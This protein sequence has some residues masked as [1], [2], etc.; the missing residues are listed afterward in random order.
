MTQ[1]QQEQNAQ[2]QSRALKI[3]LERYRVDVEIDAQYTLLENVMSTYF[4]LKDGFHVFLKELSHP[5]R[6]WEFIIH[7][8]RGY[9]L[10]YFH[11]FKDHPQGAE[12]VGLYIDIFFRAIAETSRAK[13]K[14]DAVDNLLLYLMKVIKESGPRLETFRPALDEAFRRMAAYESPT[15][16]LI[17]T[18]YYPIKRLAKTLQGRTN[19]PATDLT[20][21]NRLLIK[22]FQ[23]TFDYWLGQS[24]PWQWF[25][26]EVSGSLENDIIKAIFDDISHTKLNKWQSELNAIVAHE[27]HSSAALLE[28]LLDLPGYDEIK[29]GYRKIPRALFSAGEYNGQANLWKIVFLFHIMNLSGLSLIHEEALREINRT[30]TW[31]IQN[32]NAPKIRLLL[33]KTFEILKEQTLMFPATALNCVLN[34]GKSV[35]Q[36]DDADLI[37]DFIEAVID[38]GFQ[39]PQISGVGNDWQI[40]V[41]SA[42]IQNIRTW[43]ELIKL[44]PKWSKRL[45]SSLIINLS[46]G[47]V[48]IKDT[49]LFFRDVSELLDSGTS[50][51]FNLV[52][53]LTRL[54]PIFFNEIGAEGKLRDTSTAV[55]ELTGR[56]DKLV[57]FLRK[58]SHVESSNRV[59]GFMEATLRFWKNRKKEELLPYVPPDVYETITNGGRY[60]DGVHQVMNRLTAKGFDL[61][62]GLLAADRSQLNAALTG[63]TDVPPM[64]IERV[65]L[66]IEFYKLLNLKYNLNF[67]EIDSLLEEAESDGL[68]GVEMLRKALHETDPFQKLPR[69]LTYLERLQS[70]ILAPESYEAREDIYKKRHFAV[71]IPSMYGS[72]REK[73]FDALG[74]TFRIE[75]IVNVL[76]EDL[77]EH[78]DLTLI[79]KA[80]FY[81]IHTYLELFQRTL[82]LEGIHS[83]QFKHQ[84]DLLAASL[85]VKGF[86]IA[87]YVDIFKGFTNAVNNIIYDYFHNTHEKNLGQILARLTVKQLG[88]K[89]SPPP[90]QSEPEKW[91]HRVSEIFFRDQIALSFGLQQ[92]DR[93]LTRILNTLFLQSE[94][95]SREKLHKLLLY[96]LDRAMMPIDKPD[97]WMTGVIHLGNK[98]YNLVRLREMG[99]PVPPGFII[100]TEVFRCR[101][102]IADYKPARQNFREQIAGQIAHLEQVSGRTYGDHRNPLLFSVRS[103]SSISQPGMMDTFLNVGMNEKIAAGLATKSQNAWF[104]WDNYRRFLQGHGMAFGLSRDDFDAIIARHKELC[105]VSKKRQL[106][107][108]QMRKVALDYKRHARDN[109]VETLD[110]PMEQLYMSI[111]AVLSS[112]DSDKAKTYRKIMGIADDWGTAVTVQTMV[113]GNLSRTS[114]S[115][116]IFT[117]NPRRY[118]ESISL[119][120]DLSVGNQGE[121]V[122]SGLVTTLPISLSQQNIEMR[123]SDITLETHFPQIYNMLHQIAVDLVEEKGWS[124][125][126]IEFTFESPSAESLYILQTRDMSIREH[127]K[128]L[129]FDPL[130]LVKKPAIGHGIG[131]SG[132][133]ISG[134]VVFD[135]E[136]IDQWRK[137]EPETALILLRNDTVPDD[138]R[139]I[140]ATDALLT[141]RGGVTSHAAV[142]A[143]QLEK[144]CVVGCDA[145]TCN[146]TEKTCR[147]ENVVVKNGDFISLDGREGSIFKGQVEIE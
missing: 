81:K 43:L 1:K 38:L 19:S 49:D 96:D 94:K 67:I 36:T 37:N 91:N 65:K 21:M 105:G 87:Q 137:T 117:R 106:T 31:L 122:V 10:D 4:G 86:T 45:I 100:T 80:T 144:V 7:E 73:K 110:D 68:P 40:Q 12:A 125:Q 46:V 84:L 48:F 145:L 5:Y 114:G 39:T 124:P 27:P 77:V 60:V 103:G 58:Q 53:Q 51:V 18:S 2:F 133:A 50:S 111:D 90:E 99:L 8:A 74:F 63:I 140:F 123:D 85:D 93:F 54:F 102:I 26:E 92:L 147:F 120:G 83:A 112:W 115:G 66:S 41:N 59:L 127:S 107:G 116:V 138:I 95:L 3:N 29:D 32:E 22:Y 131:V 78:I 16:F 57:H 64:D 15:T 56:K 14:T 98:G 79:T 129:T 61:P 134:R 42:H 55:D 25:A 141:A 72:Y 121:D 130:D 34:M 23:E 109:G 101:E 126:D 33:T 76:L 24:D 71:D 136:E 88:P 75:S 52:K 9:A 113:Y 47:G 30:L 20:A 13:V 104:A 11:L 132:G 70:V 108:P 89:Y 62:R 128:T 135:L 97:N 69:L 119:W 146:E 17:L 6:N 139:E 35:Y 44:N 142:V 82:K 28:K 143:H 118:D